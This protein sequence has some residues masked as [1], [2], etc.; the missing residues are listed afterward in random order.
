MTQDLR[1]IALSQWIND[2]WPNARI[3]VASADASFRRYF[4]IHYQ[5]NTLIAMDAPPEKEDSTA[6]IEVTQRLL[7]AGVQAPKILKQSLE[8]GFLVL[9]DLGSTPYLDQLN[10]TTADALYGDALTA[11]IK[12][13]QADTT[14]LP[15]YDTGLLQL[16][17]RLMPEWFLKTY[18]GIDL[19]E[20]QQQLIQQC[21]DQIIAFIVEQPKVFVHRDYHSR[22]LMVTSTD[23]PGVIDYQ[24]AVLG[25][26]TYDAVSLLRD[27]YI[28]WSPYKVEQWALSYRDQ[29]VQAGL[30]TRVNNETF[31]RWFDLMGL[32]RHIK[33]LGIFARLYHRDGKKNYLNDLPLTLRYVMEIGKK[34]PETKALVALFEALGIPEKIT[35]GELRE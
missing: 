30:M 33:V 5:G 20:A 10:N 25:A 26:I 32:Q 1:L 16:E 9:A 14:D 8:Q 28:R 3:S 11:L 18:L 31:M 2:T 15:V 21:F 24:D 35:K 34:H 4:R 12:I 29:A 19:N 6:F 13:Q 7:A 17:M 27:C 23:N 22:N